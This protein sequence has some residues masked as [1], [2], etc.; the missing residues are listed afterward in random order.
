MVNEGETV[1]ACFKLLSQRLPG[2]AEKYIKY[3]SAC[4]LSTRRKSGAVTPTAVHSGARTR[5]KKRKSSGNRVEQ[6]QFLIRR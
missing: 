1:V 2:N 3:L 6:R 5:V 4:T